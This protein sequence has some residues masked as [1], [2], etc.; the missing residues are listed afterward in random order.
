MHQATGR[1]NR[2]GCDN[3]AECG[4][5]ILLD[6]QCAEPR[7]GRIAHQTSLKGQDM[8][9]GFSQDGLCGRAAFSR[10]PLAIDVEPLQAALADLDQS[11][12]R[13]HFN[14]DYY[15]GD[16]SGVAL[17]STES[18]VELVHGSGPAIKRQPWL[19]DSRWEQGLRGLEV[20]IRNARLLRL[21]PDS[22][23][24]EHRDYDLGG[25]DADMRLHV[26]LLAPED[27]DFMLDNQRVPMRTGE[28]WF[29][30]L[31]RPHSVNNHGTDTR[32]HLVIDCRPGPWL[33]T[34]IATG[35]SSTPAPGAGRFATAFAGFERWLQ[36]QPEASAELDALLERQAF[37]ERCLALGREQGFVFSPDQALAALRRRLRR[38]VMS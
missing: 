7:L 6:G 19:Q 11:L 8:D 1:H 23:I 20:E 29:L 35:L 25:A 26:P 38:Q 32:V 5:G 34:A 13:P 28:C 10:L 4:S 16:W 12:W 2:E 14:R 22:H 21:G 24:R 18:T 15:R 30:D 17:I 27:V 33:E 9:S 36:G 31:Y 3:R 37:I